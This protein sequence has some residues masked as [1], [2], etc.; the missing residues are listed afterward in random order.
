[1]GKEEQRKTELSMD[2]KEVKEMLE[3]WI[4]TKITSYELRGE[5]NDIVIIVPDKLKDIFV[6]E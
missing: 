2:E 3:S 6:K 5:M 1:M 4:G